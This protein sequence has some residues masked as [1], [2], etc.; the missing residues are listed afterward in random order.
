MSARVSFVIVC[1]QDATLRRANPKSYRSHTSPNDTYSQHPESRVVLIPI[2]EPL[3][4]CSQRCSHAVLTMFTTG[5]LGSVGSV[6]HMR[7]AMSLI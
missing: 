2:L 6:A 7:E 4:M 3:C 1:E 5:R